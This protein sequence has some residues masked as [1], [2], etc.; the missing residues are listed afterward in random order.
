[1]GRVSLKKTGIQSAEISGALKYIYRIVVLEVSWH[2]V[3]L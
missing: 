2:F 3:F 1:M